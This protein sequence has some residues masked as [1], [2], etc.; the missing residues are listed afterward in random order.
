MPINMPDID[1]DPATKNK[2]GKIEHITDFL[3]GFVYQLYMRPDGTFCY[4]YASRIIEKLFG[5][6]AEE[7][8]E[9][10][11]PLLDMIHPDDVE[12]VLASSFDAIGQDES[13]HS[14][15]RMVLKNGQTIWL[16]AYDIPKQFADGSILWT[17]YANDITERKSLETALEN[18]ESKFRAIVENAN[19]II[20]TLSLE[21]V[22]TY[23]S[24][25]WTEILG[26]QT[27]EV[28]QHSFEHFIHPDDLAHC[29]Q[30][31]ATMHR[32]QTKQSDI[33]Y[34]IRDSQGQWQWHISNASPIVSKEGRVIEYLGIARDITERKALAQEIERLAHYDP[35]TNL[36][37]RALFSKLFNQHLVQSKRNQ[38]GIALMFIDLD[39]FKLVNDTY[40]HECGDQLLHLT[41]ERMQRT[42]R[43]SDVVGRIGGDEFI[44]FLPELGESDSAASAALT[45]A[46]KLREVMAQPFDID[47][48][49]L[50]VSASIGV[51]VCPLH[52]SD[53]R[54]L[55]Q[56]ADKAM[57]QAKQQGRNQVV[58][59][60][61]L[62]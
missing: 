32:T 42:V 44:I 38:T 52:G 10:S 41:A 35:L 12:R 18:S 4:P 11:S 50:N 34:R 31:L 48:H 46:E 22:L 54:T 28:I 53:E 60:A 56:A 40:G 57:Y 49:S 39:N 58:L 7:V 21:G 8:A 59:A 14:Q 13:W 62:D 25:Q 5:I 37:N 15:F 16:E 23:V 6:T 36:V 3:P 47:G 29:Y 61:A 19:D 2:L 20:Y 30:V 1:A 9:D 24:P 43:A 17:G 26:H 27:H 45:V 33:E 51:A 55:S